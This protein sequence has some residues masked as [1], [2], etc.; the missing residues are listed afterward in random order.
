MKFTV[1]HNFPEV[2]RQLAQLHKDVA[3]QATTRAVNGTLAQGQTRMQRAITAE[4]NIKASA[5]RE[6]LRVK[7]ASGKAG[8]FSIEGFL[9]SPSKRGRSRNLIHFAAKQTPV[10]VMVKIKRGGPRKIIRGA[11]IINKDN[12]Y[13]GTVMIR[14]GKR[15]LPIASKQTIAVAQMFNSRRVKD[16]V[17]RFMQGKFPEVF[18]REAR[19]YTDRFNRQGAGR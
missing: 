13:G 9:E 12:Q 6:S 15:R 5:V 17:V 18:A 1:K 14:E 4:F 2:Q 8:Q 19:F 10:G 3:V 7:R 16:L 11:F